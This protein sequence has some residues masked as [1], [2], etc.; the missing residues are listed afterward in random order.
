M[1]NDSDVLFPHVIW[2]GN[3]DNLDNNV[4]KEYALEKIKNKRTKPLMKD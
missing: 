2:K 3:I 4:I 1:I